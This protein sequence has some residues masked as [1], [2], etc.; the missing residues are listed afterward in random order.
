MNPHLIK[1]VD[2]TQ[3]RFTEYVRADGSSYKVISSDENQYHTPISGIGDNWEHIPMTKLCNRGSG[4]INDNYRDGDSIHP[5]TFPSSE[6]QYNRGTH[7]WC[8]NADPAGF[9]AI[10][11]FDDCSAEGLSM[12]TTY[13]SAAS[14]VAEGSSAPKTEACATQRSGFRV[15]TRPAT[16]YATT[17][18]F[19]V[20]TTQGTLQQVSQHSGAYTQSYKEKY[21]H[22]VAAGS[23]NPTTTLNPDF[24]H[25]FHS[26]VI[27]VANTTAEGAQGQIDCET[28]WD[29]STG[30]GRYNNFDCLNKGD[31]IF[32]LNLGTRDNTACEDA[33]TSYKNIAGQSVGAGDSCF[34]KSTAL[35]FDSNPHYINM[36]T[37][38]KIGKIPK[39]I[40]KADY[41]RTYLDT[42]SATVA[43]AYDAM[44]F[45]GYRH[46]ITLNMGVNTQYLGDE[47]VEPHGAN[48]GV[49]AAGDATPDNKATIYKFHPPAL[50]STG[51]TG[52][53]YVGA[54]S[55]RGICNGDDGLCECFEGYTGDSCQTINSL[56]Q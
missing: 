53:E 22:A 12:V 3:D 50:N 2:A 49:D 14:N 9:F 54:C 16:D 45:E 25:S 19:H 18:R 6:P 5:L 4:W 35:S 43:N 47:N 7:G 17:T 56:A 31:K 21:V 32:L 10:I 55:N 48:Q 33:R 8:R 23:N 20:Y 1:L 27:H 24:V 30:L 51:T 11:Y 38:E 41:A 29:F 42:A 36:Y 40:N 13:L 52:Y 39:D 34:Y 37:V 26:N 44:H 15:L 28:A 46:Q